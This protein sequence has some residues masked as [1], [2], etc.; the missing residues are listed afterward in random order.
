ME[1]KKFLI[2]QAIATSIIAA[3]QHAGVYVVGLKDSDT[4]KSELRKDL[5]GQL[6]SVAARY[7]D[8]VTEEQHC[9]NIEDLANTLWQKHKDAGILRDGRFRVGIAQKAL[10][11]YLKN[12]LCL[13]EL[14][15]PPPHC[16]L[17]R[18]IIN[19][20]GLK[21]RERSRYDWTKLDKI[22]RYKELITRIGRASCRERVYVLV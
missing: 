22:E 18:Q 19:R 8:P 21:S 20:L 9:K 17:D 15:T 13:G 7:T 1:K 3:F 5:A 10:N 6:R 4:R 16:P 2:D 14:T 11:L 12:L